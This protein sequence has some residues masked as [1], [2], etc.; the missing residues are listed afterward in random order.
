[1]NRLQRYA[2]KLHGSRQYWH[3]RYQELKA[4]LQ[5]KGNPTFFFT[6][7]SADNYWAQL[8]SLMPQSQHRTHATR[9]NSVINSPHLTDWFFEVK[10]TDF[11]RHW[12]NETLDAE[13]HWYRYEYQ[14][15]GSI[16]AHGCAKL[17]NDPGLCKLISAAALGWSE[18]QFAK[19]ALANNLE[20]PHN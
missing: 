3:A 12:L 1:M 7:S 13:W 10:A 15:R 16:H 6:L 18:E 19:E 20:I 4:L 8:H 17:K 2:T 14:A 11:I 5:Q 9:V